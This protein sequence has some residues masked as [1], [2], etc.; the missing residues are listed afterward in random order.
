MTVIDRNGEE[1]IIDNPSDFPSPAEL[2]KAHYRKVLEPTIRANIITP[3]EFTGPVMELCA[4]RI[5]L[6]AYAYRLCKC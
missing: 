6:S 4:V 3:D 2:S 1:R 5:H